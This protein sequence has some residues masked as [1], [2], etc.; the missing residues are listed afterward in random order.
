MLPRPQN[1]GSGWPISR[2]DLDPYQAEVAEILDL[3][4]EADDVP[5]EPPVPPQDG[6]HQVWYLRSAPTRFGEKYLDEIR[7]AER[8]ALGVHANLVD[9]R[10]DDSLTRVDG[11]VF[12]GYAADDPGFTVRART[13]CLCTGGLENPRLLLNFSSQILE[14]IGNGTTSSAG[15]SAT[16]CGCRSAR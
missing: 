5:P 16:T 7:D 11:A 4:P 2:A 1:P 14:G 15:I 13:Y 8:I 10:L 3:V 6:F 12:R 9:L